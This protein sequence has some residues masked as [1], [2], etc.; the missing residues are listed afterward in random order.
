MRYQKTL[1]PFVTLALALA[2]NAVPPSYGRLFK[3]PGPPPDVPLP[4]NPPKAGIPPSPGPPPKKALPLTPDHPPWPGPPPEKAL[5][6]TPDHPPWPG[7]PPKKPLPQT[8]SEK[9]EQPD[10]AS[11]PPIPPRNPNRPATP[12]SHH[13]VPSDDSTKSTT[14][15][16]SRPLPKHADNSQV[17]PAIEAH[18]KEEKKKAPGENKSSKRKQVGVA[19]AAMVLAAG[20]GFAAGYGTEEDLSKED[21]AVW[22]FNI[23]PQALI[24]FLRTMAPGL[25]NHQLRRV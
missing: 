5:P 2:A 7:P 24:Q 15:N 14:P 17:R 1:V 6:P 22:L 19:A 25:I 10:S 8:P 11:P 16:Y 9:K 13:R 23:S 12:T 3:S 20:A 18:R 4:S 21:G